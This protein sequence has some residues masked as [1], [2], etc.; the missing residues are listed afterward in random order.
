MS[1]RRWFA[2]LKEAQRLQDEHKLQQQEE[3]MK[4]SIIIGSV[5]VVVALVMYTWHKLLP[6]K[7]DGPDYESMP[8]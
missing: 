6:K 1:C 4:K 2:W 7:T 5:T 8:G 3:R